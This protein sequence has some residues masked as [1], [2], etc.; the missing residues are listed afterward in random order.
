MKKKYDTITFLFLFLS[1][2]AIASCKNVK[3]ES[4]NTDHVAET[5]TKD[6]TASFVG[7]YTYVGPDTLDAPKCIGDFSDYFRIIVDCQGTSELL[8]SV[9]VHFDFCGHQDGR[10]GNAYAHMVDQQS[11]TVFVSCEGT[12]IQGRT[13]AHPSFVTSYWKDPFVILGGT[14][15]YKGATGAGMTNDYNSS[16]D[17]NSHHQWKGTLTMGQSE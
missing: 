4:Q 6:F 11:D 16:E 8:G 12:V 7:T 5:I 2:F 13:E 3:S 9:E 10:Y 17:P 1:A 14:G 15:K